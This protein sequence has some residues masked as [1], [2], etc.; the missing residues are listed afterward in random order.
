MTRV[1]VPGDSAARSVGADEVA[2]AIAAEAATRGEDVTVVRN[3]SRGLMW[4]E[5]LVEVATDL[6]RVAY[7]P[8]R[9]D[10]VAGLFDAGFLSGADHP[11]GHGP[12][13]SIPW[14]AE[15][16]RLTFARVGVID[17]LSLSDYV[18]HGGLVALD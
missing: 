10:D 13:E 17:P 8:V 16:N 5:P 2:V 12:T 6:G 1:Y 15:Q 11:L 4:L 14:L 7:G 3:G 18:D 9:G